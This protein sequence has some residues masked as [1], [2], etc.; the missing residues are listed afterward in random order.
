MQILPLPSRI[1][2]I[3][4]DLVDRDPGQPR[5]DFE[6]PAVKA[7]IERLAE[8][9][10]TDGVLHPIYLR[11]HPAKPGRFMLSAGECRT[12]ALRIL[13]VVE[14]EF[15]VLLDNTDYYKVSLME[16]EI[17]RDLNAI[18]RAESYKEYMDRKGCSAAELARA[19]G[20]DE[21]SV[22]RF[23]RFLE[24][25]QEVQQMVRQGSL[26]QGNL[27]DLRQFKGEL[28]K[29]IDLACRLMRGENPPEIDEA[30]LPDGKRSEATI[31]ARLPKT[32]EGLIRRILQ[33]LTRENP[34]PFLVDALLSFSEE[35][36]IQGWEY[37][38]T[39]TRENG[40]EKIANLIGSLQA[41]EQSL[42]RLPKTKRTILTGAAAAASQRRQNQQT[43]PPAPEPPA[44]PSP[45]PPVPSPLPAP[46][47]RS[48]LVVNGAQAPD[49]HFSIVG[50]KKARAEQCT[51][52]LGLLFCNPER[53]GAVV[54][55]SKKRLRSYMALSVDVNVEALAL[56]TLRVAWASWSYKPGDLQPGPQR[57]FVKKLDKMREKFGP[58]FPAA[59]SAA[60]LQDKS[61][62]PIDLNQLF[63]EQPKKK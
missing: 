8:S 38:T 47:V 57:E 43:L 44:P 60:W 33:S 5:K 12:R 19:I 13:G 21:E 16:N 18:E 15:H 51:T 22:R 41:L 53:H 37:F 63:L 4:L 25:P 24:L 11:Q 28:S 36:Q 54:N 52:V 59:V 6:S 30:S 27:R 61:A 14:F 50:E 40:A 29:Q 23:L 55:L 31:V 9:I 1:Q 3:R 56:S 45:P 32:P 39:L 10:K 46:V 2:L 62:D 7:H 20:K 42:V 34:F 49:G 58:R 35:E 26:T 17:R 48:P